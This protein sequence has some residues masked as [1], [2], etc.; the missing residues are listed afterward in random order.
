[1]LQTTMHYDATADALAITFGGSAR[2]RPI[3]R[4]IA[5]GI[6]ADYVGTQLVAIEILDASTRMN[7][8]VLA[9]VAPATEW[10][11]IAEAVAESRRQPTTLRNAIA[12]G[13]L[14]AKKHGRDWMV[15]RTALWNYLEALGP[16]GRKPTDRRAP[17]RVRRTVKASV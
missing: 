5:P 12:A 16:A 1:M 14:E 15:A 6:H 8:K 13:K 7:P 17:H 11:T 3:T 10:L 2:G 9:K 4:Q